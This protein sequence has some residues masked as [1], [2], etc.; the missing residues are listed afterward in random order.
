MPIPILIAGVGVAAGILGAG[1]HISAKETNQK[2]QQV[3][4]NA[5]RMY[6][7]AKKS[8]E[9]AQNRTEK[10]LLKLGYAKKKTLDYSMSQFVHAFEKV[11]D[12]DFRESVGLNEISKFTIGEQDI[13]QIQ[14]M[15]DIYSATIASGTAGIAAGTVVALAASGS[16]PV[17]SGALGA[18]GSCLAAGEVGA[19]AGIA[20]SALSFGAAMTPLAAVAGPAILFTGISASMKADENLE[21]ANV[22]Y[23]EAEL[24]C[25][26]MGVSETLCGAIVERSEMFHDLLDEL[27]GMFSQCT[28]LMAGV[29]KKKEG[30]F[31][32]K[33][34]T[35]GDFSAEEA[36][37]FAVT[38]S[39]A[40]AV[41]SIIDT[42]I[43]SEDGTI[44]YESGTVL[45]QTNDR[46]PYISQ[47]VVEVT[48]VNY[49]VRPVEIQKNKV[50]ASVKASN[51]SNTM[52]GNAR[53]VFG[54]VSG[55]MVASF[56]VT[57]IA[58]MVTTNVGKVFFLDS[59]TANKIAIWLIIC[60]FITMFISRFSN[61]KMEKILNYAT[62][63]GISILYFEYCRSVERMDHYIIFSI[64]MFFVIGVLMNLTERIKDGSL[65]GLYLN[66]VSVS[67]LC[68]PV[69]FLIYAL[70][71]HFIGLSAG[72]CL[73]LTGILTFFGVLGCM[74]V[75]GD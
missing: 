15:T 8:L 63:I 35:S 17:V 31:R 70:L 72:F 64:I 55:F 10:A 22:K 30:R 32:R 71:A 67:L 49:D 13:M 20:G 46:L 34:L 38:G 21:K 23:A 36:K 65:F 12:I 69:F 6:D 58:E 45:E 28:A 44:S 29:I 9:E 75:S 54:V 60:S 18:A 26:K 14:E 42:P 5:Q 39:L 11:K 1:G 61:E 53:N 48:R 37:L 66:H 62:G 57:G 25:E 50:R 3:A 2:A 47:K 19:A 51:S 59:F 43:L 56:F 27:E 24:A 52:V 73:G 16:L 7:T 33:K 4:E 40:K 41:K 74:S 68:Y